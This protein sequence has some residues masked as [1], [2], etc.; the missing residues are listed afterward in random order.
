MAALLG[1]AFYENR[2]LIDI[3]LKLFGDRSIALMST[4]FHKNSGTSAIAIGTKTLLEILKVIGK[5]VRDF[6]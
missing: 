1:C 4:Q 2:K 6:P 5:H 3:S